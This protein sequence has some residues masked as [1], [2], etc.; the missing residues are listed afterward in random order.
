MKGFSL[1]LVNISEPK[2]IREKT[3]VSQPLEALCE[4][5][6]EPGAL[7]AQDRDSPR[8]FRADVG[9]DGR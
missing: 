6:G 8:R 1:V 4:P 5:N 3:R 9:G 7:R 2:R